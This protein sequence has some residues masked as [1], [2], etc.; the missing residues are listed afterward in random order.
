M[1]P[2]FALLAA[3]GQA[4]VH[5]L[6]A[7][8][9]PLRLD[10]IAA[11]ATVPRYGMVDLVVGA[12][13]TYEDP[14]DPAQVRLDAKVTEADGRT[15]SVPGF[16]DR[17]FRRV[18]A[19][20]KETL[21]PEGPARWRLRIA[22]QA[23]GT[24]HVRLTFADST[25]I[26]R[27]QNFDFR[28]VPSEDRGFVRVGEEDGRFFKF[29]NGAS[30]WPLGP[31]LATAGPRGTFDYDD[32]LGALGDHGGNF[33]RL[34][35]GPSWT[36]LANELP[37][38]PEEGHGAG[39]FD[40]ANAW[41]LDHVLAKAR[42]KGVYAMLC[43][44]SYGS[45]RLTGSNAW[46]DHSPLNSDNGGPLRIWRDF[47]TSDRM[48][49]LYQNR[50]RYLVARYGADSHVLGWEFWNEVD[51]VSEFEPNVVRDWHQRTARY[52]AGID[53]YGHLRTTSVGASLGLRTIDQIPELDVMQSHSADEA[54]PAGTV[55]AQQS[56]KSGWAY[57][58]HFFGL[59]TADD[60]DP[61][62][63][64]DPDG[65]QIHDPIW[66]SIATGASGS[67]AAWW[68]SELLGA[69]GLFSLY[70][71]PS[72]FLAGV[73]WSTERFRQT[74]TALSLANPKTPIPAGDLVFEDGP[75]VGAQTT[76]V[77]NGAL[78]GTKPAGI[79][80]GLSM[81]PELHN[82]L[83]LRVRVADTT[84]FEIN[85]GKV[86][87]NG[88]ANLRVTLDGAP[89]LSRDFPDSNGDAKDDLR[90]YIATFPITLT[91]GVHTLHVENT[92]AD[93]VK[94]GY[95][96]VGVVPRTKPPLTAWAVV[97]DGTAMVWARVAGCTW[98]AVCEQHR[99]FAPAPPTILRLRGLR[100][101]TWRAEVWDTWAGKPTT[102]ERIKVGIDGG[103]RVALPVV[104]RDV[105]VKLVREGA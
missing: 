99:T 74:E 44:D 18:L 47:W 56:R 90:G 84:R 68:W 77:S 26:E 4:P 81:H 20:G 12:A 94:V 2:A 9:E 103:A 82:P 8:H 59:V 35:L 63:A 3:A 61:R 24:V 36:T 13:G 93:W 52:L 76:I 30:Y 33:A 32:W 41:R 25:G 51:R 14:F 11:P 88:G 98:R 38:H 23:E 6:Y 72:R 60:G 62:V 78:E 85:V 46:W 28:C 92:G 58:P 89:T 80:H 43:L 105:A 42:E 19:D 17:P 10:P 101:G 75:S 95:R 39:Q 53:A 50:L 15:Y 73:D 27:A 40:L 87:G 79:L 69:K 1:L 21:E 66:A 102:T 29:S 48:D 96:L 67:S 16:L 97:G 104:E 83:T 54:D 100:S 65:V 31:N 91:K 34:W 64:D 5:S 37:G 55:T 7:S 70:D 45:L 49:R 71:A 86:S 57:K 22:P